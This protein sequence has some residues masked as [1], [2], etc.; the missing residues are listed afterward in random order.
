MTLKKIWCVFQICLLSAVGYADCTATGQ[1]MES[2]WMHMHSGEGG[3][4]IH[5]IHD[6]RRNLTDESQ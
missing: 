5:R 1:V 6:G 4:I 2:A 3:D